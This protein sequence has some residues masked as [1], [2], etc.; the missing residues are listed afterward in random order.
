MPV[1]ARLVAGILMLIVGGIKAWTHMM[2]A[3]HLSITT[4][5]G[6]EITLSTGAPIWE[7]A[8]CWGCY[9]ALFGLGL[10]A[11]SLFQAY[12][13]RQAAAPLPARLG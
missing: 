5:L 8:H 11:V 3:G 13:A 12:K 6:R 4:C 2:A 9:V 7:R 1:H 10:V